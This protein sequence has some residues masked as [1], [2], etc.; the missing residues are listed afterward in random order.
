MWP[1]TVDHYLRMIEAGILTEK[2]RVLLWKGQLV[3]RMT[4]DRPH[5]VAMLCL[6]DALRRVVPAGNYVEPGQPMLLLRRDDTIPEP[7][8]KVVRGRIRDYSRAP[9]SRDVPLVVEVD[10]S[11]L[12]FDRGEVLELY[13][14]EAIPAYWIANIPD[15]QIEVYTQPIEAA[16]PVPAGYG[17]GTIF[18]PGDEVPVVLD[19][20]A[21]GRITVAEIF[22]ET[23]PKP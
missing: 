18:R 20:V 2:D 3:E 11:S 22:P 6:H 21:V 17:L 7:D 8:L 9:T 23:E 15:R 16:G 5:T 19:G 1:L 13:A 12:P 14:A 10:D 4:E